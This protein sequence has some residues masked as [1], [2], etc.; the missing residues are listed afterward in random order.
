MIMDEIFREIEEV[1]C[2]EF[3]EDVRI[4]LRNLPEEGMLEEEFMKKIG[5]GNIS[6]I[7]RTMYKLY[8]KGIVT[9]ER[10]EVKRRW[11]IYKW[12]LRMKNAIK[13]VI[14]I[15]EK[16]LRELIRSLETELNNKFFCPKCKRKFSYDEALFL[17]FS[18]DSCNEILQEYH[19]DIDEENKKRIEKLEDELL[20][21]RKMIEE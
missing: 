19:P 8:E 12:K 10:R 2:R 4:I 15:K 9:F 18:C 3:G 17:G 16:E 13:Y 1:L 14:Q 6:Q 20:L 11:W 5:E 21:L 7:R